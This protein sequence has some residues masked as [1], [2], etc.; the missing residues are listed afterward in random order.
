MLKIIEYRSTGISCESK[1]Y[2][3]NSEKDALIAIRNLNGKDT[4]LVVI[5]KD[6]NNSLTI[7][8]GNDGRYVCYV[9]QGLKILNLI[10]RVNTNGTVC[11]VAG[12]QRGDYPE[13][14]CADQQMVDRAASYYFR[15][16]DVDP[17][18]DWEEA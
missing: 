14:L 12:G 17:D 13:K 16:G 9:D 7:G 4:T 10:R 5:E 18:L 1:E 2:G 8:G 3:C 15:Y 11:I 6:E